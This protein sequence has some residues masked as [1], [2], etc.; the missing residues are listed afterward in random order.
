MDNQQLYTH[1]AF[2]KLSTSEKR[3]A[4]HYVSPTLAEYGKDADDVELIDLY[5]Q[6]ANTDSVPVVPLVL[7]SDGKHFALGE[8]LHSPPELSTNAG[9]TAEDQEY[10]SAVAM[11]MYISSAEMAGLGFFDTTYQYSIPD[12]LL[13]ASRRQR[14]GQPAPTKEE[15][16]ARWKAF[17]ARLEAEKRGV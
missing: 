7:A 6:A 2:A 15:L 12:I 5:K 3:A 11:D 10:Y 8:A 4:L 1:E 16:D 17:R 13:E 9:W 14:L